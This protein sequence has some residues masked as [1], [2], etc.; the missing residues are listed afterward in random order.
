MDRQR[1]MYHEDVRDRR[2]H[3][4]GSQ[5]EDTLVKILDEKEKAGHRKLTNV[6][7]RGIR[8]HHWQETVGGWE[9]V[10]EGNV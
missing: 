5:I 2:A 8:L 6:Y 4:H 7:K 1:S 3:R 10:Y 9:N